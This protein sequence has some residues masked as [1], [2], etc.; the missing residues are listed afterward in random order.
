MN[1][2]QIELGG[3]NIQV[4][5]FSEDDKGYQSKQYFLTYHLNDIEHFEQ[6]FKSIE[7]NLI[8]LCRKYIFGE[9]YGKSGK[10]RHI[11]G[12]F[13]L[14]DKQRAKWIDKHVF[15]HGSTLRKLKNWK[16]ALIYCM[17]ECN[18][19]LCSEVVK[20]PK[21]FLSKDKLNAWEQ[22][23]DFICSSEAEPSDRDIYWFWSRKGRVGKTCFCKYLHNTYDV[24][25]IGGKAADNKNCIATYINN[26]EDKRA[27]RVVVA[28]IP[29]SL[30]MDIH[31]SYEG[32]EV[33]KDMF[34]YSGKYEGA[35]VNDNS[36]HMFIFANEPP[37]K[38][39]MSLDRWLIYEILDDEGNYKES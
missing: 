27:P 20:P 37:M 17:K 38:S 30:D 6:V 2:E 15:E 5:S 3:G 21:V 25:I 13:I 33:I 26:S 16:Q 28:N 9:E 14:Y 31:L 7:L 19:V 22:K 1:V 24:C 10:T 12:A 34:F 36:P 8:P 32:M 39:K 35:Q 18:K 29:R 23:I 11:Q 4:P